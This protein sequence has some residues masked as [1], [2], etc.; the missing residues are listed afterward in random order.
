MIS[1][2]TQWLS[3]QGDRCNSYM[4]RSSYLETFPDLLTYLLMVGGAW[5]YAWNL[6]IIH[7]WLISLF[8][9]QSDPISPAQVRSR[10]IWSTLTCFP[11]ILFGITIY[12]YNRQKRLHLKVLKDTLLQEPCSQTQ[13]T[14]KNEIDEIESGWRG[15]AAKMPP[16]GWP[17]H[18]I[19]PLGIFKPFLET[20]EPETKPSAPD[21]ELVPTRI[22]VTPELPEMQAQNVRVETYDDQVVLVVS[23]IPAEK[24]KAKK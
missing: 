4:M 8:N 11:A 10:R 20:K 23:S 6:D 12:L 2:F 19:P 9:S 22:V 18:S 15:H 3:S 14:L 21:Q 17:V 5:A 16:G 24:K 7:P 1:N 13:G